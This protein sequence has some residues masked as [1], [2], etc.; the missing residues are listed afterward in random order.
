MFVTLVGAIKK[1][2]PE[3]RKMRGT[4]VAFDYVFFDVVED[5]VDERFTKIFVNQLV[6]PIQWDV[7]KGRG[8]EFLGFIRVG[9]MVAI[10]GIARRHKG[11]II[12]N[13]S[14]YRA[15]SIEILG[16]ARGHTA[17][18]ERAINKLAAGANLCRQSV[19]SPHEGVAPRSESDFKRGVPIVAGLTWD[20]W[21][22]NASEDAP[23][24]ETQV[25]Q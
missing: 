3:V 16:Q 12:V 17:W 11:G 8:E 7:P 9:D 24:S 13:A 20:L 6:W 23:A 21:S 19:S 18:P 15:P 14:Q 10:S 2:Y 5:L 22:P 25:Q 1:I 4:G